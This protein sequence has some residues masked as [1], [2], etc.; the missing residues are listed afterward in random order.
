MAQQ[1]T[2]STTSITKRIP[3]ANLIADATSSTKFTCP[4]VSIKCTR[5]DFPEV[6]ER[7]KDMGEDFIEISRSRDK[8]WVSV[9]RIYEIQGSFDIRKISLFF[10]ISKKTNAP[11]CQ[12]P[13]PIYE[14]QTLA[15]PSTR[16]CHGASAPRQQHCESSLGTTSCSARI[17]HLTLSLQNIE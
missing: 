13:K 5:C 15:Y 2:P 14:S 4:G 7:I 8:I 11:A 3:S 16:S 6:V 9:Y 10:Q 12:R 1:R 17:Y